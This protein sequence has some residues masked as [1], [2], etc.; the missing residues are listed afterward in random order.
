VYLKNKTGFLLGILDNHEL[1]GE[2]ESLFFP[3]VFPYGL[4][5]E[6]QYITKYLL[7]IGAG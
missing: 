7:F 4:I 3:T 6:G 5:L 2:K 1:I